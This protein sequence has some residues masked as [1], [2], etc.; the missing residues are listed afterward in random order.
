MRGIV[1]K[2][3]KGAAAGAQ[4][5]LPMMLEKS[6]NA[7]IAARDATIQAHQDKQHKE[8]VGIAAQ[9]RKEDV[10]FRTQEQNLAATDRASD[11]QHSADSLGIQRDQAALSAKQIN[12]ALEIGEF[13]IKQQKDLSGLRAIFMNPAS[14]PEQISDATTK[15][16]LMQDA[17]PERFSEFSGYET[18]EFGEEVRRSGVLSSTTGHVNW[19]TRGPDAALGGGG[20]QGIPQE[21]IDDLKSLKDDPSARSEFDATFGAGAAESILGPPPPPIKQGAETDLLFESIRKMTPP[22]KPKAR[23]MSPSLSRSLNTNMPL[24]SGIISSRMTGQ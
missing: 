11:N 9:T 14:T 22:V 10:A 23:P 12:Q 8:L 13:T 4:Q 17:S 15:Y 19:D 20:G 18:N 3:L 7:A 5:A 24:S 1:G 2:F 21:A 16:N 6:R